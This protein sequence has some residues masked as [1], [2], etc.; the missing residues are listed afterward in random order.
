MFG[1]HG[2]LAALKIFHRTVAEPREPGSP[3]VSAAS[4]LSHKKL[5]QTFIAAVN[6]VVWYLF[7]FETGAS[8]VTKVCSFTFVNSHSCCDMFEQFH[9][10]WICLC[11]L[12]DEQILDLLLYHQNLPSLCGHF[13]TVGNRLMSHWVKVQWDGL[14]HNNNS[15]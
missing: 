2:L 7:D 14:C 4:H 5:A 6:G 12:K 1:T 10:R 3:W 13:Y 9:E 11:Y 15:G 8:C